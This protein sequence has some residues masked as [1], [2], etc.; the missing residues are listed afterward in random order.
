MR[1]TTLGTLLLLA[2]CSAPADDAPAKTDAAPASSLAPD[3]PAG[4]RAEADLPDW[5]DPRLFVSLDSLRWAEWETQPPADREARLREL[6]IRPVRADS[7]VEFDPADGYDPNGERAIDFHFVD[8]SGDGVADVIYN[9]AWFVRSENGFGALEGTHARLWQVIG[10]RAVEVM[11]DDGSIQRVWR[12]R[13]GEPV[14][15]R[16]VHYGCCADPEWRIRYFRPVRDGGRV[17]FE[18]HRSVLGRA[19]MEMPSRF[20][21]APRR[22]TVNSDRYLLRS[23]PRIQDRPATEYPEWYEWGERGNAM[24]EYGR[25][26]R[27]IA[28]AERTDSTGRV[29]WFVR[30]DGGTP[31]RDAQ[32]GE[33]P[34]H[35]VTM[36]RLGWMS[37]RFLTAEP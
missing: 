15:F 28:I 2:A 22:F 20:M 37:S 16:V 26:A 34:E 6:G 18:E 25:G 32:V 7:I 27:G 24:A 4:A 17:R 21:S 33:D 3:R 8:F 36:D 13:A 30:M 1:P 19:E 5:D 29:W 35:P 9:G 11:D 12:G 31:P 10:G 14:S 23:A